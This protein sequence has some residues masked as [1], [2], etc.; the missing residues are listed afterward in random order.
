MDKVSNRLSFGIQRPPQGRRRAAALGLAL[1]LAAVLVA[2]AGNAADKERARAM[3]IPFDGTPGPLNAIT[4]VAGVEVGFTTLIQG[5]GKL[6]IGK[7]PVRTGV[8]AILP[9]GKSADPVF[10]GFYSF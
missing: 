4:D 5:E 7:G 3:G 9:R 8:T 6:E 1:G 2:T 10:A